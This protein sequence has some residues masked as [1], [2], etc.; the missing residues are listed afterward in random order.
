LTLHENDFFG[1]W[2]Y[3]ARISVFGLS[4]D[5]AHFVYAGSMGDDT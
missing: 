2:I 4:V 1:Y 3:I 5:G